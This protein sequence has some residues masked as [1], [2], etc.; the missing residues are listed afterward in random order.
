MD[1]QFVP[2]EQFGG[3]SPMGSGLLPSVSRTQSL[4]DQLRGKSAAPAA[5]SSARTVEQIGGLALG[6]ALSG[7]ATA[8]GWGDPAVALLGLA[9]LGYGLTNGQPMLATVGQGVLAPVIAE[10]V[11][12][13]MAAPTRAASNLVDMPRPAARTT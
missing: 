6:A 1:M 11:R 12:K 3:S 10:Y 4:I 5:L 8:P 9:A 7:A 2:L 13:T